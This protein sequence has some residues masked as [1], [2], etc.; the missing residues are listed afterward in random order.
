VRGPGDETALRG[1]S[2]AL[3]PGSFHVVAGGPGKTEVLRLIA[4]VDRP[5]AGVVQ[6]FGRDVAT[7]SRRE[8]ALARRRIGA[9]LYPLRFIDHLSV[10]DNAALAPRV[11]G[12]KPADFAGEVDAILKWT[13]LFRRADARPAELTGVERHRLALARAL[14]N[15]PELLVV[16][17]PDGAMEAAD[18]LRGQKL[19]DEIGRAGATVVAA[20]RDEA[21][22]E[23]RPVL[24]LQE[25]RGVLVERP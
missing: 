21:W 11:I 25:G 14:A 12:R 5:S 19:L 20:S 2:F 3:A 24:R 10:W 17:E 1:L 6:V 22:A 18:A 9:V 16:D 15:R 13:G 7:L 4:L 23:G 8:A